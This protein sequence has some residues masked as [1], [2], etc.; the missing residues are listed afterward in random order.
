M[1]TFCLTVFLL[2]LLHSQPKLCGTALFC[3]NFLVHF[4][5]DHTDRQIFEMMIVGTPSPDDTWRASLSGATPSRLPKE[6]HVV[7]SPIWTS[8]GRS[9]RHSRTSHPDVSIS[10]L[11]MLSG[12]LA[13]VHKPCYVIPTACHRIP[14]SL[15]SSDGVSGRPVRTSFA[16]DSKELS[17][18]LDCFSDQKA[19]K[20][21]KLN[22]I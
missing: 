22:T 3:E 16:M 5:K 4:P 19:I 9:I 12:S 1:L 13:K 20:T 10:Y 15:H 8:S 18:I 7:R 2:L 11:D 21:P 17:S 6:G 14:Y